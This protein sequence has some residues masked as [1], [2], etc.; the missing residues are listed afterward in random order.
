MYIVIA[1]I[2]LS[3][4]ILAH[5]LGHYLAAKRVGIEVVEFSMG[6]GPK[7]FSFGGSPKQELQNNEE[8]TES[9]GPEPMVKTEFAWRLI[10]FGASVRMTGEA[11]GDKETSYSYINKTPWEKTQV[12]AAGPLMNLLLALI[13]YVLTYS[14]LGI[15]VPVDKP[16]VGTIVNGTPA[17]RSGLES[18]D[19]I[20]AINDKTVK[21]WKGIVDI[22]SKTPR[23]QSV[24]I[25]YQ[26]DKTV[27]T[28]K[29]IPKW[30]E[31]Q[32]ASQI[33]I[34]APMGMEK[35]GLINGIKLGFIDSYDKTV[36]ILKSLV[37]VF[38]GQVSSKDL[39]G[40]VGITKMIGDYAQAGLIYLLSFTA[41][42]SINLGLFNLLPFPALDGSKIVFSALEAVRKKPIEPDTENAIHFV[43]FALL[44]MLLVFVT[45][46]DI[47]R[48]IRGS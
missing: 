27:K 2:V 43:G 38:S 4:V 47:L 12:A 9:N 46:N 45:Y 36:L 33:G 3:I 15:P 34:T 21:S 25:K 32:K 42:L 17:S 26:H 44:M 7:L 5:E 16:V 11:V 14:L 22:V 1:L 10:P 41:L 30:N 6:F 8:T 39:A 13:I 31:S 29:I 35:Q 37:I 40:P 23:G 48:L 19:L 18:G 28:E 20:L 24:T